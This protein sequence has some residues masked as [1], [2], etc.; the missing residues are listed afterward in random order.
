MFNEN[1]KALRKQ[2]GYSQ[3]ELAIK[4]NVVRQTVSKWEKGLS[5]PDVEM[6]Q[7]IADVLEVNI[8]ELLDSSLPKI[9]DD[10]NK[11]AEQ[12]GKIAEQMAIKNQHS[13]KIGKIVKSIFIVLIVI[14][15]AFTA[16]AV[17][18]LISFS[19]RT[20]TTT[21]E[22]S[23]DYGNSIKYSLDEMEEAVEIIQRKVESWD[24]CTLNAIR[25]S[26]DE[27]NNAKNLKWLTEI[28]LAYDKSGAYV[29][30]IMFTADFTTSK[31]PTSGFNSNFEYEDYQFWL[32][33]EENGNWVLLTWGY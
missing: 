32:A 26:S 24:G 23:I 22:T 9:E 15:I 21:V 19:H 10:N 33:R 30:C 3:E 2:K 6:L 28:A 7:N 4:L 17:S 20:E 5:V 8:S 16:L 31:N 18:G 25:Y 11:V 1:L 27:E 29:D 14:I 13:R 12:L